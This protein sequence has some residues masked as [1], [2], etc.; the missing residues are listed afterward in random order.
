MKGFEN[1]MKNFKGKYE[2]EKFSI[3]YYETMIEK[4][5]DILKF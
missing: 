5:L 1:S 3:Y 2:Y 4:L